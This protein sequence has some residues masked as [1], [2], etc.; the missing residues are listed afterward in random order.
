MKERLADAL[1]AL[2]YNDSVI[3]FRNTLIEVKR[4]L[5]A[6][7][8]DEDLAFSRHQ[9]EEYCAEVRKRLDCKKLPRVFILRQLINCRK[10]G[11]MKKV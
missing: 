1:K 5:F 3:T 6:E 8:T 4:A 10:N 9:A 2:G 7:Y 11:L